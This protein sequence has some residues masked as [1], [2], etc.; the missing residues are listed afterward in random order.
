MKQAIDKIRNTLAPLYSQGEIESFIRIIFDN[1]LHYSPVD[2]IMHKDSIL[3]DYM[4][5]KID[6]VI[7]DLVHHR[8][9][10]YIFSDAYF[11]G[12]HFIVT[13]DTLIP[14]PETEELID[15]I[16]SENDSYDLSVL[17]IGTGS[18][19]IAISLA[20]A[21]KFATV[22]GVDIS[23]KALDVAKQ[24]AEKL[25]AKVS[26][27]HLD[28]LTAE[29]PLTP[30]YDIIV[31]NPP[32]ICEWEKATMDA[33]VLNYEPE[34]A[35]FVSDSDP[36]LFYR[37]IA[38]YSQKALKPKGTLYFEMNNR[39]AAITCTMLKEHGYCNIT[40]H[41]DIHNLPRMV[42]ATKTID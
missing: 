38:I 17:D 19:C 23:K 28:I 7:E 1:L 34:T 10:Q 9:I 11:H 16:I 29:A 8:P 3:S 40:I 20:L 36:L 2:I 31:S 35:L 21:L 41:K 5:S 25:H 12:H 4:T 27:K 39:Y 18:G 14:R 33:N 22:V 24:N 26:F 15:L 32:Y 30:I 37:T 6:K 42:S 13:P